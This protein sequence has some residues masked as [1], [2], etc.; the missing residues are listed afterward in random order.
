MKKIGEPERSCGNGCQGK[1]LRGKLSTWPRRTL[2]SPS[3]CN[4]AST[5]PFSFFEAAPVGLAWLNK[6]IIKNTGGEKI[7][8]KNTH[9]HD[10][11]QYAYRDGIP[12]LLALLLM[13]AE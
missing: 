4:V 7:K 5:E 11:N 10:A 3:L 8:K 2:A 1:Y 6:I 13:G 9:A 12:A